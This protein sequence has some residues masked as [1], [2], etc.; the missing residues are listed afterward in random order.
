MERV[1][2]I[3]LGTTNSCVAIVEEGVPTVIPNRG[4]YKTTPSM[5]AITEAGKRLCG[6]IAK[7]QAIT[8]AENT[9]YAAKRLI[10]RKWSSPQVKNA[11]L[12]A[13]YKIVEGPHGDVRI[14]LRDKTYSVPEISAMVLQ[15]MKLFAEDYL[16]EPISKAVITVPAYFN[17]NQRQATKDAGQIAGLD[18]IRIVNEPTAAALAYGF[19]KNVEKTIAVFDLGGGTFDISVLEIGAGGVFKVIATAGDTFL[20][21]EDF[22]ARVIDW[23]VQGFKEQHDVDLRQDRMALQRLKDAAEKAKC[24]LSSVLE[25]EI[26]LPFIISSARNEAL[27]LQRTLSRAELEGLCEDLVERCVEICSQTLEDARLERDEIEDVVLVGG[28]T[29]MP[30]VQEAVR[31]FFER[32]PCKGVHPDEV[33]ALGAAVQGAALVDETKQMILLDVTPHA[34]G[35]MT[36]G[37]NF[38]ELIP[39]NTTVPT[40]RSKIFT[41]S[42]DNQ[43]AV[44]ILVMQGEHT[45]ATDNELLGEFIL[46]GLRRA[47]KGQVEIEVTF[48]IN[49]DGIVSVSAKDLE[50][51][52]LQS[53][54][55][56]ASSGLT[57]EEVGEMMEAAK[58][59]LVDRRASD[60]FEG[61]RQEAEKL[62]AEIER[63]FPQVEQ[64]V[65]SSDFGRDAI[66]KARGIV[67]RSR[68]AIGRRDAAAVK[69]QM[70]ALS[71]THRMF[72]G[73]VARPQG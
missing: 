38:E 17:D 7:R 71:R 54:Q 35:I 19:G 16:N 14:Q 57:K 45:K 63:M 62:I 18:V 59:Y 70:E 60:Q 53:I 56:T 47:P 20:G 4:G 8:N 37:S 50:T 30:R 43:T 66:G 42:R 36:F 34:L 29:R 64:I 40:A 67:D 51:G 39:Q 49:S 22:D 33:V 46:T 23:L 11:I 15:E 10:G 58:E 31:D 73:V 25:T 72:K 32:E 5:V 9:V 69:E 55:V 65:A 52:Q 26:N 2:G 21:G 1:I 12:T 61:V 6:H 68:Q 3:D 27:H 41:T 13:S 24:E 28:M 44:K 48:E